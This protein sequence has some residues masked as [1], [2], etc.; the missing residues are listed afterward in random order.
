MRGSARKVAWHTWRQEGLAFREHSFDVVVSFE[1]IEHLREPNEFLVEVHRVL[2]PG[3]LF[4]CSSPNAAMAPID[5]QPS[6]PHHL[7]EFTVPELRALVS[8]FF[9]VVEVHGQLY[10]SV[11]GQ[12]R[13][14][15]TIRELLF[16]LGG[17]RLVWRAWNHTGV[18]PAVPAS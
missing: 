18:S 6:G 9:A 17:L 12:R 3:G 4:L 14:L 5:G 13:L 1:T 7:R 10:A 15:T 16:R 8:R 2:K 11:G